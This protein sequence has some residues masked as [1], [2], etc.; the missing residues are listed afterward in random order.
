MSVGDNETMIPMSAVTATS[1]A[2]TIK[3][4]IPADRTS[5]RNIDMS[6]VS[7]I[8]ADASGASIQGFRAGAPSFCCWQKR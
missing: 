2:I 7:Q 6:Q 8:A 4:A 3:T 5:E 1:T